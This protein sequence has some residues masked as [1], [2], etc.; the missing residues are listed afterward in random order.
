[1][2]GLTVRQPWAQAIATGAKT[3]ENRTTGY[4]WR[5]PLAIHAGLA[6]SD[7][8]A[9]DERIA[10]WHGARL[11]LAVPCHPMPLPELFP[12]GAVVAVSELVDAHPDTGCCRPWGESAYVE[13]SGRRRTAIWHL[14][15]ENTRAL[16]EPVPYRG[17]QGLWPVPEY[18]AECLAEALA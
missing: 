10:E 18:L 4:S 1:M 15:L 16:A 3:V 2:R 11:G 9:A 6:W 5:G 14:V 8:G 12:E 17:R 13:A 7:R